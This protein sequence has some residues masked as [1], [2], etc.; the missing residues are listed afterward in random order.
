[1]DRLAPETLAQLKEE[2]DTTLPSAE[3][4][5]QSGERYLNADGAVR[6]ATAPLPAQLV[7]RLNNDPSAALP[8]GDFPTMCAM[9][10]VDLIQSATPLQ[11]PVWSLFANVTPAWRFG[12]AGNEFVSPFAPSADVSADVVTQLV[13]V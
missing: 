5:V 6:V 10:C 8:L 1:L 12:A 2:I 3:T 11:S 7:M 9:L 4:I 13:T